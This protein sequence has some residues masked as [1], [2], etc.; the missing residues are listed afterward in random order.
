MQC[1][2]IRRSTRFSSMHSLCLRVLDHVAAP[3][4]EQSVVAAGGPVARVAPLHQDGLEPRIA[5][6][7]VPPRRLW[8]HPPI[9][10]TSVAIR[11]IP[12]T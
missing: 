5:A 6:Y 10:S 9:T 8:R 12:R 11:R 4:V 3:A 2:M 7:R 1:G